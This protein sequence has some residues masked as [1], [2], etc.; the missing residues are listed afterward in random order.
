M[1]LQTHIKNDLWLAIQST[2]EAGNYSHAIVDAMHY[3]SNILRDR[4]GVDG[5][6]KSLVGQAL[7]GDSPPIKNQ[8]T[9]N[10]NR[11]K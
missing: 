2:Y 5:D 11:K 1:N 3:M 8:Q 10:R 7:G 4:T 9:S 6:G